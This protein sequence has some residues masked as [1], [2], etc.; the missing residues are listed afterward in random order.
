MALLRGNKG[1]RKLVGKGVALLTF[2][3]YLRDPS[4]ESDRALAL[5]RLILGS[6]KLVGKGESP[7]AFLRQ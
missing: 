3:R 2:L 4:L 7:I 6:L 5:L 1:S